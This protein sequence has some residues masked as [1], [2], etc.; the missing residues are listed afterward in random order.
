MKDNDQ[1]LSMSNRV[2][3]TRQVGRFCGVD[4]TTVI[5]WTKRGK[6]KAFRTAG[7]HRRITAEELL[8]FMK[9]YSIPVPPELA[10]GHAPKVLAINT[11]PGIADALSDR[12]YRV[13]TAHGSFEAGNRL[14]AFKP[15]IV[16]TD[17][18]RA[19]IIRKIK[20][21]DKKVRILAVAGRA[22][23]EAGKKALKE[24]ADE[25]IGKPFSTE[26]FLKAI[27][28]LIPPYPPLSKGGERGFVK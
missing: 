3:T 22:D 26:Q 6:I 1:E 19:D 14:A 4:L 15:D 5:N 13:E 2:F 16:V 7:G 27:E 9:E 10:S 20:E 24:G 18:G 8:R 17:A 25:C 21:A 23:S 11:D 28:K 12:Q